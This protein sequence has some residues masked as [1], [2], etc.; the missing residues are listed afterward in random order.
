MTNTTSGAPG[1]SGRAAMIVLALA[2]ALAVVLAGLVTQPAGAKPKDAKSLYTVTELNT[3]T[4]PGELW[5]NTI[6]RD[7]NK[8]GRIAG[9]GQN[10][11]G[12]QRAFLWSNGKMLDLGVPDNEN[13]SFSRAR[14]INASGKVVG[15]WGPVGQTGLKAFLY[16]DR[17]MKDLN[18]LVTEPSEPQWNLVSAQAINNRGQIVGSGTVGDH[19]HAFVY[20]KGE[21]TDLGDVLSESYG[22]PYSVAWGINNSGDVVGTSGSSA[23]QS[24][25][26]VYSASDGS[27]RKL[28]VSDNDVLNDYSVSEAVGI[29]AR[30]DVIGWAFMAASQGAPRGRAFRFEAGETQ[31]GLLYPLPADPEVLGDT[32]DLYTRARD[33]DQTGLVVGWSRDN[34]SGGQARQFSAVLWKNGQPRDL[35]DLIPENSGWQL[36][37]VYAI[38]KR[39]QIVGSGFLNGQLRAC[40]LTRR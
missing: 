29:N 40:L 10:P 20:R 34:D 9:Q 33:I 17:Q 36:T 31:P 16:E 15:E 28:D 5:T 21:V 13:L 14:S 24:E 2:G 1:V 4:K 25:A 6:A 32:D 27:V 37:D 11:S 23:T 30:G 26:F 7:I 35:N 38:N 3:E 12:Q 8:S 22:D 19:T 18:F 39:G